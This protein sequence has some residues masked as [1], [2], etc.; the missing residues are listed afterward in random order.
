MSKKKKQVKNLWIIDLIIKSLNRKDAITIFSGLQQTHYEC[1]A[2]T[3]PL[4]CLN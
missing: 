3:Y 1:L 4:Y 2:K